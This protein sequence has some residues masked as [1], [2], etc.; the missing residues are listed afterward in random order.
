M[1]IFH[2]TSELYKSTIPNWQSITID[3][4]A[5]VEH[6]SSAVECH[7]YSL[8]IIAAWLEC[9]PEKPSWYRNGMSGDEKCKAL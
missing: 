3:L 2:F 9:F 5:R 4:P 1:K 8:R 6:G 7:L